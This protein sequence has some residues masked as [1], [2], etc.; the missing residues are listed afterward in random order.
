MED[1]FC[2]FC[3]KNNSQLV[4]E[5]NNFKGRKCCEC[6]LIYV[7][8]RPEFLEIQNLYSHDKAQKYAD[9]FIPVSFSKRLHARHTLKIIKKFLK[10]GSIL[11]AGAGAGYFLDE[12]GKKGFKVYGNELN[13]IEANFIRNSL[14]IVCEESPLNVNSFGQK[15][16]DIIYHCNLLSHLYSPITYFK[17]IY[18]KL[19][20]NGILIFETGNIAEL[21]KKYRKV[22]TGFG[23]PDHLFFFGE[24][25]LKKLLKQTGF[26]FIEVNRYSILP[27]LLV[28]KT[29]GWLIKFL[30]FRKKKRILEGNNI[31]E[32]NFKKMKLK[33]II[34][35]MWD[36]FCYIMSYKIGCILPK[37]GKP[38]TLIVVARK[39]KV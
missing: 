35:N 10:N 12:A 27:Q 23:F 31:E 16:F 2:I 13:K 19:E 11:E 1:I 26:T 33:N 22:F 15:K 25:S 5:D 37:K 24:E 21:N 36:L 28:Q 29:L 20:D 4:I 18:S 34:Y 39:I 8:P 3:K 9:T 17:T 32:F 14:G 6:G 7:S 30:K 38:Q